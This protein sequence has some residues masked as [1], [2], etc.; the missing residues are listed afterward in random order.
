MLLS[1]QA[2]ASLRKNWKT[3]AGVE[4]SH[5]SFTPKD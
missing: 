2:L 4:P 1:S 3:L 5:S